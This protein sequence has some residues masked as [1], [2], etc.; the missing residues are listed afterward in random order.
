MRYISVFAN[1]VLHELHASAG[2]S[3]LSVAESRR[4]LR[5]ALVSLLLPSSGSRAAAASGPADA[6]PS[7]SVVCTLPAEA[8]YE[9]TS[10]LR[11]A[12]ALT[13]QTLS[14]FFQVHAG[15]WVRNGHHVRGQAMTYQH[16]HFCYSML[17]ADLSLLQVLWNISF[18]KPFCTIFIF[19]NS[20]PL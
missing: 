13:M 4:I 1:L 16:G 9:A 20:L 17:D 11:C 12:A 6:P 3:S 7:S 15:L 10:T 14:G 8:E 2:S 18:Y 19:R 5:E